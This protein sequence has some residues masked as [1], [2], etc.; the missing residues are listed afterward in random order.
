MKRLNLLFLAPILCFYSTSGW[1]EDEKI[2]AQI[3][4]QSGLFYKPNV[5][6]PGIYVF[7]I[8]D[9]VVKQ[10]ALWG[11]SAQLD[12]D[13]SLATSKGSITIPSGTIL[14][15]LTVSGVPNI[16]DNKVIFCTVSKEG[17]ENSVNYGFGATRG[18]WSS[19]VDGRICVVDENNDG[20][21]DLGFL[22]NSGKR[23]DRIPQK[24]DSI[25]LNVQELR[26]SGDEFRVEILFWLITP[27]VFHLKIYNRNRN[28]SFKSLSYDGLIIGKDF[29]LPKGYTLPY[30]VSFFGSKFR[31]LSA[32]RKKKQITVEFGEKDETTLVPIPT[33]MVTSFR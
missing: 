11:L 13:L 25:N 12:S 22:I 27:T 32:D 17:I 18:I 7:D 26:S 10:P 23:S 14:P 9:A 29:F 6:E 3:T 21:T 16:D 4:S 24:V 2:N 20:K 28:I 5:N 15:A 19:T 31:V 33:H 30:D 1:C 8:D